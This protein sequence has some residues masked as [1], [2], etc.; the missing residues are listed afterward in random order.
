MSQ[1]FNLLVLASHPVQYQTPFYKLLGK[2]KE[3]DLTVLYCSDW[4]LK[5]YTDK[6]FNRKIKWDISLLDGYNSK[7]LPNISIIPNPSKFW[8]LINPQVIKELESKRYDALWLHGWSNFSTWIAMFAAIKNKVPILLRCETNLSLYVSPVKV[9]FKKLILRW[10]F[11]RVSG[12]LAI[13]KYNKDFYK[14][15][16]VPE[17]KIF[18][19]PYCVD[20]EFF[21]SK[22]KELLPL[23]EKIKEKLCMKKKLPIILFVGKLIPNKRPMDLLKAFKLL[24]NEVR[25]A[26]VFVGD[27]PEREE[28]ES[29][30]TNNNLEN[31]YFMG[32]KN[33]TELPEFYAISDVFV[34]PSEH[35]PWGLVV[36]EAMCFGLP[37]IVSNKVGAGG[38]LVK[39]NINGFVYSVS[40]INT[41]VRHLKYL[42]INATKRKEMGM[43][44]NEIISKW[45]YKEGVEGL[46]K[47]LISIKEKDFKK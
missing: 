9:F 11:K 3:L 17:E 32:F 21:L 34:L 16:G 45:S 5:E 1:P 46:L 25:S 39:E 2:Q 36:N 23:K 37:I 24:N 19:V 4:G 8:G 35:E 15:Y 18:L 22:A 13:G 38:D 43:K 47:C 27:G 28:L 40:D 6:G 42:L 44:S 10:L 41:L 7:F 14:S 33:Q 31:V 12:F 20:N 29:Y 30:T 26:L